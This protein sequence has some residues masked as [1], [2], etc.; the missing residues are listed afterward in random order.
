MGDVANEIW[1]AAYFYIKGVMHNQSTK[2]C[3]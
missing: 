2:K 1:A 3:G